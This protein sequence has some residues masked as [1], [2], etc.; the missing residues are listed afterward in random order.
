MEPCGNYA[1]GLS[2]CAGI[3]LRGNIG[4]I[5]LWCITSSALKSCVHS[6]ST[7]THVFAPN[8]NSEIITNS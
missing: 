4:E 8:T 6:E 2:S 7:L 5:D 1:G 3:K